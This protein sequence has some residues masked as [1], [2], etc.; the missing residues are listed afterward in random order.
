M[1]QSKPRQLLSTKINVGVK[2]AVAAAIER[3]RKLGESI[4]V[5]Q[6]GKVVILTADRISP[7]S[8]EK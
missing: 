3:H 5:W 1:K 7:I 4:A 6:D 8:D 2:A